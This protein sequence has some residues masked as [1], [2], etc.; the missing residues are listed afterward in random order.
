[1]AD[2]ER[3]AQSEGLD[4]LSKIL[5]KSFGQGPTAEVMQELFASVA[6]ARRA[7]T[8]SLAPEAG[9]TLASAGVATPVRANTFYGAP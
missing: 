2:L 7:G 9:L 8:L 6:T 1:M 4:R 5:T 3:L